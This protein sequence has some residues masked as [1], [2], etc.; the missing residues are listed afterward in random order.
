ML[1]KP[2]LQDE[3]ILACLR[4][5]YGIDAGE[6]EFLPLGYDPNAGVYRITVN[7]GTDYFLKVKKG[8]VDANSLAVPRFLRDHGIEQ[9]VAPLP[10][11]DGRLN[12][13][14]DPFAVILYPFVQGE[15]VMDVGMPDD[16][17][18][19]L[20]TVVRK[21]H[22]LPLLPELALQMPRETFVPPK[23]DMLRGVDAKI[24]AA[25]GVFEDEIQQATADVWRE[26]RDI[27]LRIT[28]RAE[29]LGRTLQSR[30]FDFVI[31]HADIHTANILIDGEQRFH[32]VDWDGALLAPKERDLMFV[33]GAG[34]GGAVAYDEKQ[35]LFFQGYGETEIDM[36]VLAYYRCDWV[37][38]DVGEFG[39]T[40]FDPSA[41]DE[42]RADNARLVRGMFNPGET[43]EVADQ[44]VV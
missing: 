37:V 33:T 28:D 44:S 15:A 24:M 19:E 39:Y 17:W 9:V 35:T 10:T 5:D 23:I 6:I 34:A 7:D 16:K 25:D 20:G 8:G 26:K 22:T 12:A 32:I 40:I 4:A 21:M 2:D 1:E 3:A 42:T 29:A 11:T 41:G 14:I 38:Q 36:R 30:A 43:V 18:I 27:I 13:S 31:C